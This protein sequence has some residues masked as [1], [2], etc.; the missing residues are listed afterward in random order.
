[1]KIKQNL[2]KN[3]VFPNKN[4][5]KKSILSVILPPTKTITKLKLQDISYPTIPKEKNFKGPQFHFQE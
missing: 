1:M 4:P 2:S 5:I 3:K